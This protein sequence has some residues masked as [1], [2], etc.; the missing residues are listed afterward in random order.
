MLILLTDD[1]LGVQVQQLL[2]SVWGK[3]E[4]IDWKK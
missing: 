4:Q 1:L 3:G 2:L